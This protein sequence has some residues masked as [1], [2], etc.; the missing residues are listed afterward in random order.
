MN[1]LI[2]NE[3]C[4]RNFNKYPEEIKRYE[5]GYVNYVYRICFGQDIFVVRINLNK[6]I[7]TDTIYWLDKL[8]KIGVPVP[9]VMYKGMYDK[10]SYLILNYIDGDDLG[11]IYADLSAY[12]KREIARDIVNIQNIVATLPEN[13]GYGYLTSYNDENYKNSW[14]EVIEE[15]LN[16]SSYRI[17]ENMIFDYTKV[18]KVEKLLEKYDNYFASIKPIP[19]LDDISS[20]N[21][22]IKQG[23]LTGIIDIDEVCFGDKLYYVALSNM[24]LMGLGYDTKY[25]DYLMDE[26][27]ASELEREILTLY[28]LVFCV[29]F[30]SEK[31]MKFKDEV[32]KVSENQIRH[33][34]KIYEELYN[35][36][37]H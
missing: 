12:E 28:T 11:N 7:Y 25:I 20:K 37:K 2:V 18:D 4:F 16:R 33:L 27:K 19:F 34:N 5:I 23:K 35:K 17:K 31:G 1:D 6:N 30:M 9:K 10:Y 32:V 14:K 24:A 29:D 13:R 21:V 26:M 3:I 8:I 36:L 22:L 15:H